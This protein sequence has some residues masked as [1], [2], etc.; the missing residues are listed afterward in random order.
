VVAVGGVGEMLGTGG[1][2]SPSPSPAAAGFPRRRATPCGGGPKSSTERRSSCRRRSNSCPRWSG[3]SLCDRLEAHRACGWPVRRLLRAASGASG[4]G[5][6]RWAESGR[7]WA[8]AVVGRRPHHP[9]LPADCGPGLLLVV[10]APYPVAVVG[11]AGR[12]HGRR[13]RRRKFLKKVFAVLWR[14]PVSGVWLSVPS[15]PI[16]V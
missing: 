15:D 5:W 6:S 7:C 14:T 1:G 16:P 11:R 9:P 3:R 8:R 4:R 12:D 2:G 10:A 13:R